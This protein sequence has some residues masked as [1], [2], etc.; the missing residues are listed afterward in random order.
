MIYLYPREE[1][2]TDGR[3]PTAQEQEEVWEGGGW[4]PWR[5]RSRRGGRPVGRGGGE[6]ARRRRTRRQR[7]RR[8]KEK[9]AVEGE[10]SSASGP[11]LAH[12]T[13]ICKAY[14]PH[15]TGPN[16][17]WPTIL[18]LLNSPIYSPQFQIICKLY[19]LQLSNC[20]FWIHLPPQFQ[21]YCKFWIYLPP[22]FQIYL[23]F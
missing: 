18:L 5:R 4:S 12:L 16:L 17:T 2:D 21:I 9:G 22:Q 19:S 10:A 6:R 1:E 3:V 7:R 14:G 11:G 20:K 15:W 8:A 23:L 13:S